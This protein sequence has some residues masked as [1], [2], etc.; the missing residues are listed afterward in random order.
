M[1]W[2]TFIFFLCPDVASATEAARHLSLDPMLM[3]DE[4]R[5]TRERAGT[6][7]QVV[8]DF[9]LPDGRVVIIGK[10]RMAD[11]SSGYSAGLA[12]EIY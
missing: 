4:C 3:P 10:V 2:V 12:P 7:D 6:V 8:S 9:A 5:W 11:G 1:N